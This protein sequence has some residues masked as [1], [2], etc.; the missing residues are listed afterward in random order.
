MASVGKIDLAVTVTHRTSATVDI[1]GFALLK[2]EDPANLYLKLYL[3]NDGDEIRISKQKTASFPKN[4]IFYLSH[5]APDAE[6]SALTL[7]CSVWRATSS[8][9]RHQCLGGCS[10]ALATFPA[11]SY[12]LF[13]A[14]DRKNP[15]SPCSPLLCQPQ[16]TPTS[17]RRS[18]Y[19]RKPALSSLHANQHVSQC[20]QTQ[21]PT[22][23]I[24]R[25][26]VAARS[27]TEALL[28]RPQR[29]SRLGRG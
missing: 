14:E 3:A 12:R 1:Q 24:S 27:A 23:C 22:V 15:A 17:T 28:Q 11:R 2:N 5:L 13:A 20:C 18:R 8:I 25:Q 6:T 21:Q 10:L 29:V 26:H 16:P 4:F 19:G 9:A 7:E